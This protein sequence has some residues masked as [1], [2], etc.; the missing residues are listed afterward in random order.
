M[1]STARRLLVSIPT[2]GDPNFFRSVVFVVEHNADGALGVV[3]NQPTETRVDAVLEPWA[4]LSAAPGVVFVGGP[5]QQHE[6]LIGLARVGELD[7]GDGGAWQPLLGRVG[8]VDLGRD[9]LDAR[10]DIEAVR[11]FAGYS[12]WGPSQLDGELDA[13]GWFVVDA[14]PDDLLTPD[15]AGL[16]RAVLRRQGGDVAVSANYPLGDG[17]ATN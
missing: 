16:W 7:P 2:L 12:G 9:P 1:A 3:L 8:T 4:P 14:H 13:G 10:P 6:A 15:P 11:I 5:V 17:P